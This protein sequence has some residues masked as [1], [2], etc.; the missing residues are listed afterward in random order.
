MKTM[1]KAQVERMEEKDRT[2]E[3]VEF[4]TGTLKTR[5]S[6]CSAKTNPLGTFLRGCDWTFLAERS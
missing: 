1:S 4:I 6:E 5:H 2:G 3:P